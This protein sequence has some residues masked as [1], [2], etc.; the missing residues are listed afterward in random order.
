MRNLLKLDATSGAPD[1]LFASGPDGPG[2]SDGPNGMVLTL[3][4]S[5]NSLY[6]GG[7]FTQYRGNPAERLVKL[8]L[9]EGA[10][11]AAFNQASGFNST[12]ST[13][14][15]SGADLFAGGS[16][17]SYR[18][19]QANRLA[20]LDTASG[21]LKSG[22]GDQ[23][24]ITTS[25]GSPQ[26]LALAISGDSL[27]V[28]GSFNRYRGA[29]VTANLL[30]LDRNTGALDAQFHSSTAPGPSGMV[31]SLAVS[32]SS[33]LAGG[34]F[35][36]YRNTEVGRLTKVDLAT[37]E[38]DP[39]FL[40]DTG[41]N[42][43]ITALLP[44]G[45]AI[46]VGGAF[47]SFGG[48]K[49]ERLAKVHLPSQQLD[50][51]FHSTA[52]G[53]DNTIYA[54]ALE[55]NQL[56]A[57]GIARFYRGSDT[58]S[59][60][61]K[62]NTQ[63]GDRVSSFQPPNLSGSL[64][65]LVVAGNS[66]FAGGLLFSQGTNHHLLKLDSQSGAEDPGFTSGLPY[67]GATVR[68]LALRFLPVSDPSAA[69][70]LYV[71]GSF[72]SY[73]GVAVADLVKIDVNSGARDTGFLEGGAGS[74]DSV[75][76]LALRG[77]ALFVGGKFSQFA[78]NQ[79]SGLAKLDADTGIPDSSFTSGL[80]AGKQINVLLA[81]GSALFVGGNFDQWNGAPAGR[82]T[83]LFGEN[84]APNPAFV[85]PAL[86]STVH[87]LALREGGNT[88]FVGGAFRTQQPTQGGGPAP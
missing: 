32:G 55:G 44:L 62:L 75:Y 15:I 50:S 63:S 79:T 20:R 14:A 5:G 53:F 59:L 83:Q 27:F 39:L 29:S 88:L 47:D 24:G 43:N 64:H 52:G 28:G 85:D 9:P 30:K 86:N 67:S 56:F 17:I 22:P 42:G 40:R 82:L 49:A 80:P 48:D 54:L 73:Q 26:V 4:L 35:L 25:S 2:P 34:G 10:L 8:S 76:S 7:A 84:G 70:T 3:A 58:G 41:L 87:S 45:H 65:S 77:D 78:G 12:V 69:A 51:D 61:T 66:L 37:G 57:G 31:L 81:S 1:E 72:E 11:D 13:V 46:L 23:G 36:K 19:N 16:F 21:D 33:L 6:A 74:N 18:G 68:A 71:G 60:L 38:L